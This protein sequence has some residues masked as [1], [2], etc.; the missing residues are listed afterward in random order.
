VCERRTGQ[1]LALL[2]R[3][4]ALAHGAQHVLVPLGVHDDGYRRVVLGGGTD[5]RRPADVDLLDTL[6]G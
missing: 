3:E 2:Q 5:H 4:P 1:P 6:V